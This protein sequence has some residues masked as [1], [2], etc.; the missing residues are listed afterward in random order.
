MRLSSAGASDRGRKRT[1]NED[2]FLVLEDLRL[3]AVADGVGGQKAGEVASAI[4]VETLAESMPGLLGRGDRTPPAGAGSGAEREPSAL[5]YAVSLANKK[6]LEAVRERPEQAGMGTT[7]TA[8][9]FA[10]GL[11]HLAHIGDSRAYLLR[12]G[13]LRQLTADHSLVADQVRAGAMTPQ[14]ARTSALRHV[15]TRALGLGDAVESELLEQDVRKD[16]VFLLCSDGLTEMVDDTAIRNVLTASGP[17]KA[18]QEL[19]DA[20]NKA[21][22]VDNITAVVVKVLEVER[23]H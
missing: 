16:D 21:G 11:A 4:A 13:R 19:I 20:A 15:I 22:G 8:L 17:K 18:V 9:L 23:G 1:N 10:Q 6:I 12:S 5:R 2:S 3:F 14:Q 7:L